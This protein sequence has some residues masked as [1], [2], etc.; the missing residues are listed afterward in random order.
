VATSRAFLYLACKLDPPR[1]YCLQFPSLGGDFEGENI[2]NHVVEPVHNMHTFLCP[3]NEFQT[4]LHINYFDLQLRLI[5]QDIL[6]YCKILLWMMSDVEN[7]RELKPE[8]CYKRGGKRKSYFLVNHVSCKSRVHLCLS[9][10]DLK[11]G[12]NKWTRKLR[13]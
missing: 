13:Q 2:M 5:C 4:F 12:A 7:L 11:A 3:L 9:S 8:K 1:H 10:K 6:T